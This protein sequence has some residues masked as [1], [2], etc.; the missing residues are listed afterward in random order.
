AALLGIA[1]DR[2]GVR[3]RVLNPREVNLVALGGALDSELL[4]LNYGRVRQL[5]SEYPVLVIPGFFGT[6]PEG[7]THV[8]G[9][10]GSDLTAVF[11]ARA[12]QDRCRLLKDV[13]GIYETDPAVTQ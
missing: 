11:L 10:G 9:R 6:D 1:L 12:L 8:L 13:D 7:R 3:T 2:S 5:L 4:A